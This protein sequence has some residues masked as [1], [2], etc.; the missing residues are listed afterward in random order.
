MLYDR[1]YL[2]GIDYSSGLRAARYTWLDTTGGSFFGIS[3]NLLVSFSYLGILFLVLY[4]RHISF[5]KKWLLIFGILFGVLGHAILNGGR[6]NLLLAFVMLLIAFLLKNNHKS[7]N[8][9]NIIN[10]NN[11]IYFTIFIFL[12]IYIFYIIQSSANLGNSD[13]KNLFELGVSAMY[14][15]VNKDFHAKDYSNLYIL[16]VYS[17]AYLYHGQ[18]TAQVSSTLTNLDGNYTFSSAITY[19]LEKYRIITPLGEKYFSDTGAFIS[20]PGAFYYDYGYLGVVLLS[21]LL[22]IMLGI[23]FIFLNSS[24]IGTFKMMYIIFVLYVIFMSPILPAYGLS[25]FN[26]IILSF[27]L[28]YLVNIIFYKSRIIYI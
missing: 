19:M 18:W 5:Y 26:F 25:Y 8:N 13:L 14:G 17:L 27:I 28:L 16:I 22:G 9:K 12:I 20:L 6:S 1:I 3:G 24:K 11:F 21:I 23:V 2:R 10:F 15:E 4:N 7:I